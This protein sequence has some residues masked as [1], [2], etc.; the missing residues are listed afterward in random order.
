MRNEMTGHQVPRTFNPLT[1]CYF[2]SIHQRASDYAHR[3]LPIA[4]L[5][6]HAYPSLSSQNSSQTTSSQSTID[7][8]TE[9]QLSDIES[10]VKQNRDKTIKKIVERVLQCEPHMH[11][12]LKKIEA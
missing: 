9:K 12:N 6:T 8:S 1:T 11:A 2:P 4:I 5:N 3:P 7:Q 10:N